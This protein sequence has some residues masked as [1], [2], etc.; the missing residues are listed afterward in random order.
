MWKNNAAERAN[1]AAVLEDV[2]GALAVLSTETVAA[3]LNEWLS[4]WD[5]PAECGYTSDQATDV[6]AIHYTLCRLRP[7]AVE[8]AQSGIGRPA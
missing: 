7:D 3:V 6:E 5:D 4:V 8:L 1:R 2:A